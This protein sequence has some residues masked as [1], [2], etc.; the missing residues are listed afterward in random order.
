MDS[1]CLICFESHPTK[2]CP[3]RKQQN[4]PDCH[5]F[6]KR[7]ADHTAICGMKTWIHQ[8][9]K[10]L[11]AMPPV[12]RVIVGCNRPMRF[13]YDGCWRKF[14]EG[15]ELY[16][17]ESGALIR[18]K[19]DNDF[20]VLTTSFAP[21]R[22]LVAVRENGTFVG[23]LLLLSSKTRFLVAKGLNEPFDR[24][25]AKKSHT[26]KTTL[27]VGIGSIDDLCISAMITPSQKLARTFEMRFDKFTKRFDIPIGINLIDSDTTQIENADCTFCHGA[28][29][30]SSCEKILSRC[31][32]CH[33]SIT[34]KQDHVESCSASD[35][36]KSDYV[37][38]YVKIPAVRMVISFGSPIH[39]MINGSPTLAQAGTELFSSM[40]DAHF[41]FETSSKITIKTTGFT[42]IRVPIVIRDNNGRE[43]RFTEKLVLMTSLDRTVIAAAGSRIVS[44]TNILNDFQ[45]NTPIVLFLFGPDVN[46]KIDAYSGGII[47]KYDVA[48]DYFSKKYEIPK[49]LDVKSNHFATKMFDAD[50]P[51]KKF[52]RQ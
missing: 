11:Y 40:A 32:D 29:H 17:A 39:Y 34:K 30:D 10:D 42:R 44:E 25:E 51:I 48:F 20:S 28:H 52:K 3:E 36:L 50:L 8:P 13:F 37:D 16:S 47:H 43:P 18:F 21:I 33:V 14:T 5:V 7:F 45:H 24:H 12:E 2:E 22:I 6:I 9:Y 31:F 38:I 46:I 15:A 41:K 27:I 4:C 35:W 26:W 49:D 19:T 23:K 1:D